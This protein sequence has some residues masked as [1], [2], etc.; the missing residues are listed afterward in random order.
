LDDYPSIDIRK[1]KNIDVEFQVDVRY[2]ASYNH[3][4]DYKIYGNCPYFLN[5]LQQHPGNNPWPT[6]PTNQNY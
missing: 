6:H 3:L 4:Q 1:L 5:S 2:W